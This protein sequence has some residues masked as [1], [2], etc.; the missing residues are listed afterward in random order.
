MSEILY[1]FSANNSA[2]DEIS[3]G[4]A[5]LEQ[6]NDD[7]DTVFKTLGTVYTGQGAAALNT[8]HTMISTKIGDHLDAMRKTQQG[9]QDQQDHMQ[10]LDRSNAAQF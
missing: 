8:Q 6:A 5:D 9:A 10:A 3:R 4:I 1:N 2:L 7:I